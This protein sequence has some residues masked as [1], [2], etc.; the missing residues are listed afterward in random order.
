MY[1][2]HIENRNQLVF[3]RDAIYKWVIESNKEAVA[4]RHMENLYQ[5]MDHHCL[6]TAN[7]EYPR[8]IRL[9]HSILVPLH[10]AL[11]DHTTNLYEQLLENVDQDRCDGITGDVISPMMDN[12]MVGTTLEERVAAIIRK[13]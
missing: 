11:S 5:M 12:V 10:T 13:L 8:D 3:L 1:I 6:N 7:K 9:F 4:T 2:L